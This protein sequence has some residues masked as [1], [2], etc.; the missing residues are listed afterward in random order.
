[1]RPIIILPPDTMSDADIKALRDNDLCV[2]VA[3]DPARVKFLDPIPAAAQRGK[4]EDAA[5]GLSRVLLNKQWGNYTS[6]GTIGVNTISKI[7]IDI[8]M[9]GTKLDPAGS[10]EDQEREYFSEQKMVALQQLAKEEA[11][12]MRAAAKAAQKE[13]GKQ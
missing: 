2:V 12:A 9:K 1:M 6:D 11:R 4:I 13:K 3:K 5:I 8:L 10:R 7:Y